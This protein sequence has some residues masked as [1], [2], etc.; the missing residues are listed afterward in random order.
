M[1]IGM[2]M[3]GVEVALIFALRFGLRRGI[4]WPITLMAVLAAGLLAAGGREALLG[5]L[6][7]SDG[8]GY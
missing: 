2:V 6:D 5:Y 4:D 7:A 1:G 8:K 3:G